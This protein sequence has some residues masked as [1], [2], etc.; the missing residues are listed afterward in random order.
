LQNPVIAAIRKIPEDTSPEKSAQISDKLFKNKK[1]L[2][3]AK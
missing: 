2:Q 3:V 1:L